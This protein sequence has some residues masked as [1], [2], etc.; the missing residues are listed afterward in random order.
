MRIVLVIGLVTG[1]AL[2]ASCSTGALVA[3]NLPEWAG[4][5]P[6][7]TPPRAGSPGYEAYLREIRGQQPGSA[8]PAAAA[9]SA[10]AAAPGQPAA[11][12]SPPAVAPSQPAAAPSPPPRAPREPVDEPI[13]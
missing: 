10:P 7:G 12:P 6:K 4:G 11:A 13:H 2:L 1:G 9:P 5:L 3:D 8:A